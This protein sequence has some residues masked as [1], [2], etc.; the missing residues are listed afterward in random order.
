MSRH[1]FAAIVTHHGIAA[2]NRGETPSN[3]TTLQKLLWQGQVHTTVSAEER[4]G[5]GMK[6]FAPINGR[7]INLVVGKR[8]MVQLSSMMTCSVS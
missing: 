6:T 3:V 8:R 4:I 2:N 1:L 5:C 7:I